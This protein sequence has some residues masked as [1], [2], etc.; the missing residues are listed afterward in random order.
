MKRM[1]KVKKALSAVILGF[2]LLILSSSANA[3]L[4]V[5]DYTAILQTFSNFV[6]E[7][8]YLENQLTTVKKQLDSL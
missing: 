3:T 7:S 6:K 4:P 5:I 8:Y 1:K 2:S